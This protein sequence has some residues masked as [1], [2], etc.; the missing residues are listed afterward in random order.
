MKL[1]FTIDGTPVPYQRAGGGKTGHRYTEPESRAYQAGV[2]AKAWSATLL[3]R[4][5]TG[6]SWPDRGACAKERPRPRRTRAP[7][8]DCAWCSRRYRF[9]LLIV[10]PDRRTRDLDNI[11][12][13]ILDGCKG[14]LYRDDRQAYVGKKEPQLDRDRPRVEV[15]VEVAP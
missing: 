11:E 12:K 6:E 9:Q 2:K 10:L 14:A 3:R 15:T 4:I 13:A 5:T 7:K 8:C 1:L